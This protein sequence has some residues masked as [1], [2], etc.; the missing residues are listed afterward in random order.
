[1]YEPKPMTEQAVN[2]LGRIFFTAFCLGTCGTGIVLSL[3]LGGV[4]LWGVI[5]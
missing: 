2:I 3:Y 1:M 4:L 5:G